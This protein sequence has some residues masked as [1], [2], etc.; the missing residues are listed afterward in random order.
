MR[1]GQALGRADR[2]TSMLLLPRSSRAWLAGFGV[3]AVAL[4]LLV[5][6]GGAPRHIAADSIQ[7]QHLSVTF[8]TNG[9][10]LVTWRDTPGNAQDWVSV[11]HAGVPDDTY[12]STWTYTGAQRFGSYNAGR[13]APG[14][15]EARLYLDW[16]NGG[17]QVVDRVHF[18]VQ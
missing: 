14:D 7:S 11:V 12:E 16:P 1:Q 8:G 13:L 15:Y 3:L 2:L 18:R 4:V 5:G 10:V 9:D 17:Y 6:V